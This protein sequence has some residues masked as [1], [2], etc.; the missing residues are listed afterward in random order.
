MPDTLVWII[1]AAI[2]VAVVSV[3]LKKRRGPKIPDALRPGQSL[4][5]FAATD[6]Q[7]NPVQSARLVGVPTVMLFVRG[8]W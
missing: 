2:V 8:N 7:G 3:A 1:G 6:E 5:D 4:P